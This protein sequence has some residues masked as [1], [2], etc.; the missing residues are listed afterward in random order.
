MLYL[1][2]KV[3]SAVG[4]G[5][6]LKRADTRSLDRLSLIRINY[7]AAAV[8]GFFASVALNQPHISNSAALL[9]A[10]TGLLFVAGLLVWSRA[11]Q[12]AGLALSVVAMRTAVV[13]PLVAAVFIWH[14]QP[15]MLEITGSVLALLALALI[16]YDVAR[17]EPDPALIPHR[18]FAGSSALLWLSLL[19][20]A[21]GLVMTAAL[22][23]RKEL[24]LTE[25]MPFQTVIF[26]SAFFV[27]TLLY[28]LRSARGGD[29]TALPDRGRGGQLPAASDRVPA[30]G[31]TP[32]AL[33]WGALLGTANFGNYLFLVLALSVLPGLVVYPVIAAGEVGLMAV[34][35]VV[36]WK[37]KVGVRSWLGIAL[38]VLALVLIQLGKS[39]AA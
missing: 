22:I 19:F 29:M 2:F 18:S 17:R 31:T 35:G 3:A 6:V 23:F 38:A 27:T 4:M 21:D 1:L 36:L 7:A 8:I 25:T 5:L 32:A 28:Y 9:A 37:E 20:L 11:I 33:K 15:S 16:L 34:A 24:P 13:I 30:L 14:E 26:V 10:I 39:A 12:A